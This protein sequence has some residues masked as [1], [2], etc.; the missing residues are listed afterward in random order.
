MAN[1]NPHDPKTDKK[2]AQQTGEQ[3]GSIKGEQARQPERA[4][5]P[6]GSEIETRVSSRRRG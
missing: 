5:L 1:T 4:D 3:Y 2:P 6:R